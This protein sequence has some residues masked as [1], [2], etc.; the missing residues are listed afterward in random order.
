MTIS[1]T[2]RSFETRRQYIRR[3]RTLGG[4]QYSNRKFEQLA[5]ANKL[6]Q[7]TGDSFG[8]YSNFYVFIIFQ[9]L[10]RFMKTDRQILFK[11]FL[12]SSKKKL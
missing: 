7:A 2:S 3:N 6:K 1:V 12:T 4:S 11:S 5:R 9:S 10:N 8:C